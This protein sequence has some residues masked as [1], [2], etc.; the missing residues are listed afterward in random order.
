VQC[1]EDAKGA[2]AHDRAAVGV[3]AGR[4]RFKENKRRRS[5]QRGHRTRRRRRRRSRRNKR[6]RHKDVQQLKSEAQPVQIGLAPYHHGN[7]GAGWKEHDPP[8]SDVCKEKTPEPPSH[9]MIRKAERRRREEAREEEKKEKTGAIDVTTQTFTSRRRTRRK[10]KEERK[11]NLKHTSRRFGQ[12]RDGLD[13]LTKRDRVPGYLSGR[14][15]ARTLPVHSRLAI[16]RWWWC[17]GLCTCDCI[18]TKRRGRTSSREGNDS[19]VVRIC[20]VEGASD[21][22]NRHAHRVAQSFCVGRAPSIRHST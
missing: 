20:N 6:R 8:I 17:R 4:E 15:A 5:G 22:M 9:S 18:G 19:V 10:E 14:M 3:A 13:R 7:S 11:P 2:T 12:K 21:G 16:E 1:R